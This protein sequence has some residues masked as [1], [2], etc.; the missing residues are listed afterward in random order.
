MITVDITG[1]SIKDITLE[2]ERD[3][4]W[5]IIPVIFMTL[6]AGLLLLKLKKSPSESEKMQVKIDY[7][8]EAL[9]MLDKAENI[10]SK[11]PKKAYE[12]VSEAVR[13]FYKH[14][15]SLDTELTVSSI[16]KTLV[17]KEKEN[18][19]DVLHQCEMIEFARAGSE[20]QGFKNIISISRKLIK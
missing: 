5:L 11:D 15:F 12:K 19:L 18:T 17:K 2:K 3:W 16:E 20:T 6:L 9:K 14:K 4:S 10:Y 1:E 8:A 7:K 13:F